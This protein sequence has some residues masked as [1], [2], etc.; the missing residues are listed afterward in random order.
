M[1]RATYETWVI[2]PRSIETR[3]K[4]LFNELSPQLRFTS[5]I[6]QLGRRTGVVAVGAERIIRHSSDIHKSNGIARTVHAQANETTIV[7][8]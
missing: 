6:V 5:M 4:F 8:G 3:T 7:A 1:K 2:W